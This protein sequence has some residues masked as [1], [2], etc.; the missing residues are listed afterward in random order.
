[1]VTNRSRCRIDT[2]DPNAGMPWDRADLFFLAAAVERGMTVEEVAGF[3]RRPPS[4]VQKKAK[5]L[6]RSR[7]KEPRS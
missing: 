3:L 1:M 6:A 4:E 7:R 5:E 2:L